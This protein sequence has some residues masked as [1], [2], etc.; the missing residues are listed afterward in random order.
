MDYLIKVLLTTDQLASKE[1]KDFSKEY[2]FVHV[3]SS[4][5]FPQANGQA[6]RT[7]RT[8]KNL[9]RKAEDPYKAM[10]DYRNTCT[11]IEEIGLSPAQMFLGRRLKTDL[12]TTSHKKGRQ[13]LNFDRHPGI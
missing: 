1:F 13:K 10:L 9:L 4:P 12:P 6:E 8:L 5:H 11:N 2:N 3:T 7:V